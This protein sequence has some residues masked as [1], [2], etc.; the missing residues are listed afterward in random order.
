MFKQ[1]KTLLTA[2]IVLFIAVLVF[3]GAYQ[4]FAPTAAEGAKTISIEVLDHNQER[5][6][7]SIR[8]DAEYLIDAMKETP[9]FT[10]SGYEGPY[11]L[12]LTAINGITADWEKD[13]A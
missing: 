6:S 12:T 9:K 2:A 7:Y 5:T 10:F 1:N 13:N 11:G 8:T 3:F 4:L